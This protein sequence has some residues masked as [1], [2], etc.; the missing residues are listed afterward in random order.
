MQNFKGNNWSARKVDQIYIVSVKD[1]A[2]I[3]DA[4][5]DFVKS[6]NIQAGEI[7]GIG[8][9]NE[10]T[11]RFF[12]PSNKN[13][14]DKTFNEQME[15]T[16]ISGNVSE[17]EGKPVLHMHVTL[18]REDYTALAGHLLDAKIRGAGEFI[19]YPLNTRIVKI[20]NEEVGI[21]FYDFEN[22]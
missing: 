8:A 18:G 3:V 21:N 17:I 7:T 10:V 12:K 16:N 14:V 4:L 2:S 13:Y 5:T 11:L 15:M 19:F 6:Q 20:K 22:K 1:R 9:V